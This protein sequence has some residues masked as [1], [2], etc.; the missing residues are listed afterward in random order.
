MRAHT[1]D[2]LIVKGRSDISAARRAIVL[3]AHG[4]EGSAPFLVR[5]IES[6]HQALVFPGPDAVIVT[7]AEQSERDRATGRSNLISG[8]PG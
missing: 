1:G 6:G 4:P 7:A 8:H 3:E 2:W 5:W